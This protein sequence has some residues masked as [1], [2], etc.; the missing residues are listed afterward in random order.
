MTKIN[1]SNKKLFTALMLTSLYASA[2]I[3]EKGEFDLDWRNGEVLT[4]TLFS[5][6]LACGV[7]Q[8]Y[9][10][11][12]S[13]LNAIEDGY[14]VSGYIY[15]LLL[16]RLDQPRQSAIL[17]LS[18][19]GSVTSSYGENGVFCA[20]GPGYGALMM[21]NSDSALV[22]DTYQTSSGATTSNDLAG[23]QVTRVTTQGMLDS[24]FGV[25]GTNGTTW[26]QMPQTQGFGDLEAVKQLDNGEIK[27]IGRVHYPEFFTQ[28]TSLTLESN[29]DNLTMQ[30]YSPYT[31]GQA[32]PN[33]FEV[34]SGA[35]GTAVLSDGTWYQNMVFREYDSNF[36]P[37]GYIA[38][39]RK[40]F[41]DGNLDINFG[42]QGELTI[43]PEGLTFFPASLLLTPNQKLLIAGVAH[44]EGDNSQPNLHLIRLE[45]DGSLDSSFPESVN[46]PLS[47]EPL[48]VGEEHFIHVS[49]KSVITSVE[50]EILLNLGISRT[51][52]SATSTTN[53]NLNQL[54]AL[55]SQGELMTDIFDGGILALDDQFKI[56]QL[57]EQ[58]DGKLLLVGRCMINNIWQ[59]CIKSMNWNNPDSSGNSDD[60]NSEGTQQ[61]SGSGSIPISSLVIF[62]FGLYFLRK[63]N[64]RFFIK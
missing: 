28:P 11:N 50:N 35:T 41:S 3:A 58:P 24:N 8:A 38:L 54:I 10:D 13:K 22:V 12:A 6:S 2:S 23:I 26:A 55:S 48:S 36:Q 46:L 7:E 59:S 34:S 39:I 30:Q 49:V 43:A 37:L 51:I 9:F 33:F 4:A 20:E 52:V 29:G 16:D 19:D 5:S 31:G 57:V 21:T 25:D 40:Y 64:N 1:L 62:L 27:V 15:N 61:S 14:L 44:P 45:L 53:E 60:E 63:N 47:I 18:L 56:T 42:D 32:N 17:K